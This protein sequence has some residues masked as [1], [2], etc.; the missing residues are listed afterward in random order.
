VFSTAR[1]KGGGDVARTV[2]ARLFVRRDCAANMIDAARVRSPGFQVASSTRVARKLFDTAS[3]EDAAAAAAAAALP[4]SSNQRISLEA[5]SLTSTST[6]KTTTEHLER[7]VKAETDAQV[8]AALALM[9]EELDEDFDEDDEDF[10]CSGNVVED[11]LVYATSKIGLASRAPTS[12]L[13]EAKAMEARRDPQKFAGHVHDSYGNGAKASLLFH[14]P[15]KGSTKN[16]VVEFEVFRGSPRI[17]VEG[18]EWRKASL[19]NRS[20]MTLASIF[21]SAFSKQNEKCLTQLPPHRLL[22]ADDGTTFYIVDLEARVLASTWDCM[23]FFFLNIID[24]FAQRHSFKHDRVV[25][26][27]AQRIDLVCRELERLG[28]PILVIGG[29]GTH[30]VLRDFFL[31]ISDRLSSLTTESIDHTIMLTHVHQPCAAVRERA[32]ENDAALEN[33]LRVAFADLDV[34]NITVWRDRFSGNTSK[35]SKVCSFLKRRAQEDI[36]MQDLNSY[37]R[38]HGNKPL[39]HRDFKHYVWV[40]NVRQS[41]K[42][43]S[44]QSFR[45]DVRFDRLAAMGLDLTLSANESLSIAF[46]EHIPPESHPDAL[47]AYVGESGSPWSHRVF[48]KLENRLRS[49]D[50]D[51]RELSF[52]SLGH[53]ETMGVA[54]KFLT[55]SKC[56]CRLYAGKTQA[57]SDGPEVLRI[58]FKHFPQFM[59][60]VE[61]TMTV[62]NIDKEVDLDAEKFLARVTKTYDEIEE[63]KRA[64]ARR[65]RAVFESKRKF[66]RYP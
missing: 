62:L 63:R 57:N 44:P 7:L 30:G 20:M 26:G 34:D 3:A 65:K 60:L 61:D 32:P 36:V 53:E 18:K 59:D 11:S 48:K 49:K 45:D 13:A 2:R 10:W 47:L 27:R 9:G 12:P 35:M 43:L 21:R 5:L 52:V 14:S 37:W 22:H 66:T 40:S 28:Q 39:I 4:G 58:L 41:Y 16:D 25:D 31:A 1:G 46:I 15:T 55:L 29:R 19:R 23:P 8:Q 24:A 6:E 42:E 50:P 51:F 33:I 38:N 56:Y 54:K 17:V 64:A